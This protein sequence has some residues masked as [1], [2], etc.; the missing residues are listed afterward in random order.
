MAFLKKTS[1]RTLCVASAWML[2]TATMAPSAALADS[3]A[4]SDRNCQSCQHGGHSCGRCGG[5][6]GDCECRL[7]HHRDPYFYVPPLGASVDAMIATQVANGEAAQMVLYHYDFVRG[8]AE[9]NFRGARRLQKLSS[10]LLSNPY[11][12]I[13]Q[14][15]IGNLKLDAARVTA[16]QEAVALLPVP[17]APD[18]VVIGEPPSRPLDGI[19]AEVV[20]DLWLRLMYTGA[21]QPYGV[22]DSGGVLRSPIAGPSPGVINPNE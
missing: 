1:S 15:T 18:R 19:D 8:R 17:I 21:Y 16:I 22:D 7:E 2:A 20:N 10:R 11:P 4:C 9:L 12:L 13:I 3:R 5:A 6:Y 14:P